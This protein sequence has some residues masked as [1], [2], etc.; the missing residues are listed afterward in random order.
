MFQLYQKGSLPIGMI[1]DIFNINSDDVDEE[2][3]KDLFTVKDATY[4]EM[5]RQAYSSMGDKLIENTD[6]VKQVAESIVGPTGKKLKYT[7]E[8]AGEE[9]EGG[10]ESF[11]LGGNEDS[12]GE[13]EGGFSLDNLGNEGD[14]EPVS[15]GEDGFSLDDA[16]GKGTEKPADESDS[17]EGSESTDDKVKDYIDNFKNEEDNGADSSAREYLDNIV[18]DSSDENAEKYIDSFLGNG[19]GRERESSEDAQEAVLV[20]DNL[21]QESTSSGNDV[22]DFLTGN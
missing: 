11:G 14:E 15:D 10:D 12:G 2:L 22:A 19:S 1:L 21:R 5:L 8:D 18:G 13:E 17:G 16:V 9:G 4:N 6:L 7:G 3:K 20:D